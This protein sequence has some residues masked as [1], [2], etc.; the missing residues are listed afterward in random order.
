MTKILVI[1]DEAA[2]R[3]EILDMLDAE[4]FVSLS[5][6][7]GQ[8][9][10]KTAIAEIPDLIICDVMMP[11]LDGY[12]VLQGVRTHPATAMIPFIFLTAKGSIEDLRH[13][14]NLGADDY[15]IKPFTYKDLLEAV[16]VRLAKQQLVFDMQHKIEEL[17]QSNLL[18]DE[19][20]MTASHELRAPVTNII[21]AVQMLQ[22]ARSAEQ[23]QRYINLLQ[24]EC[25]RE[26]NLIND[27]LDLHRLEVNE[28]PLQLEPLKL[29]YWVT[30]IAEP[31]TERAQ[32]RQQTLWVNIP[33]HVPPLLI[34]CAD[35]KRI[36]SE[37]LNNACKYTAPGGK[38]S[39]EAH[40]N[41]L[42]NPHQM[43][44]TPTVTLVVTNE[45]EIAAPA[46]PQL[47]NLF[48]RVPNG[49]PWRQGGSGLGLAIVKRLVERMKGTIQVTSEAG[50]TQF[51][52][53]LPAQIEPKN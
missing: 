35:F 38:I 28:R 10:V 27:L 13:G 18:K 33:P 6:E 52:L 23:K 3:S 12:G 25:S 22:Q 4:G 53:Q 42:A 29:Q 16:R 1:E 26:I 31:F 49:D 51:I 32:T 47:F 48:Y 36:L 19:F 8:A 37:L 17:Q 11:V 45:A 50:W 39:I 24:V 21:M 40:R 41:P 34:D 46:L 44:A 7:N 43:P 14:M 30:T 2:L 20:V 15:I 5:A 9:G